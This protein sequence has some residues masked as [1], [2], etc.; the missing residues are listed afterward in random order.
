MN[1]LGVTFCSS[2]QRSM[3]KTSAYTMTMDW[4]PSTGNP[5]EVEKIKKDICKV[6]HDHDLKI[7]VK[8][9]TTRVNFLDLTLDLQSEKYCPYTKE[10]NVPLSVQ[11]KPNHPPSILTNILNPSTTGSLKY[12]LIKNASIMLKASIKKCS[13]KGVIIGTCHSMPHQT[14]H[15]PTK[16]QTTKHPMDKYT[17]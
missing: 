8:A 10:G 17:I 9:N 13:T 2:L 15:P 14:R 11:R 7:T 3:A 1:W 12:P 4:Q 16:K 6:F 5:Q